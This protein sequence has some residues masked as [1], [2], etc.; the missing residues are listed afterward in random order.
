MKLTTIVG[1]VCVIRNDYSGIG[2]HVMVYH[3]LSANLDEQIVSL[4]VRYISQIDGHQSSKSCFE[5]SAGHY[6]AAVFD[7]KANGRMEEYPAKV[8]MLRVEGS[9]V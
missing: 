4:S 2:T 7:L 6:W 9:C 5:V 1:Q 3:K 8:K